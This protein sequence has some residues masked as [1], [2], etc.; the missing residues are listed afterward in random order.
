MKNLKE[1]LSLL[2]KNKI[3]ITIKEEYPS[4]ERGFPETFLFL[5]SKEGSIKIPQTLID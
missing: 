3:K 2:R 1:L 5:E 4:G